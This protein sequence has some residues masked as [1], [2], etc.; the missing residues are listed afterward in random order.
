MLPVTTKSLQAL[1]FTQ[2]SAS[3]G[4]D[5]ASVIYTVKLGPGVAPGDYILKVFA[6]DVESGSVALANTPVKVRRKR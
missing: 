3:L 2:K 1:Q 4:E 6:L 5:D